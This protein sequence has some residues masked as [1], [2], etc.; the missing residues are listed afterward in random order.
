VLLIS[1]ENK[2]ELGEIGLEHFYR[3]NVTKAR[4]KGRAIVGTVMYFHVPKRQGIS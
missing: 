1:D 4:E 3:I 2:M